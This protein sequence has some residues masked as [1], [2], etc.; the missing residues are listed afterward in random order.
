MNWLKETIKL[1]NL[2]YKKEA[3][4]EAKIK[5]ERDAANMKTRTRHVECYVYARE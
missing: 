3:I 2:T 1:S 4:A 5:N